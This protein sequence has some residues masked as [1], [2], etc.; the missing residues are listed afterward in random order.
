[1][2]NFE[3]DLCVFLKKLERVDFSLRP[4][5]KATSFHLN[6]LTAD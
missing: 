4:V 5:E 6:R 3:F 2:E 1:M